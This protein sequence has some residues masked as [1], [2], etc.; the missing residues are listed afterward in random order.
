MLLKVCSQ[1]LSDAK[2]GCF[3]EQCLSKDSDPKGQGAHARADANGGTDNFR[4]DDV[5]P[6]T[7][8]TQSVLCPYLA[9]MSLV[10]QKRRA[11][12]VVP[13]GDPNR[14]FGPIA[15][16]DLTEDRPHVNFHGGIADI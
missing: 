13:R 9:D 8:L 2:S 10:W 11:H 16:T 14:G 5:R 3:E 12:A 4:G 15:D 6:N 7:G 1:R